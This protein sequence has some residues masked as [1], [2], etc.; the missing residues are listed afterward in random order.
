VSELKT[1]AGRFCHQG[2]YWPA[3]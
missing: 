1:R 2:W 3:C